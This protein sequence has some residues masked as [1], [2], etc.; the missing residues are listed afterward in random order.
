MFEKF[1]SSFNPLKGCVPM[2]AAVSFAVRLAVLSLFVKSTVPAWPV[3]VVPI[4]FWRVTVNVRDAPAPVE[5]RKP[6][7]CEA[8]RA[9]APGA[10]TERRGLAGRRDYCL[11]AGASLAAFLFLFT[12]FSS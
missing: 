12:W 11:V 8:G 4:A 2:S 1:T 5:E 7:I 6:L 10:Q 9:S 3:P